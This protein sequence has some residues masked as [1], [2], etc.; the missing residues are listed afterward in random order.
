MNKIKAKLINELVLVLFWH[1]IS[2]F[3]YTL[4][5]LGSLMRAPEYPICAL[6]HIVNSTR[7]RN[8]VLKVQKS[9]LEYDQT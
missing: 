6:I 1:H 7:L 4:L 5:G 2:S 8:G 9:P 3:D